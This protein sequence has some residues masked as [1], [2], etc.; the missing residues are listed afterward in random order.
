[1]NFIYYLTCKKQ[2]ETK[3]SKDN[4]FTNISKPNYLMSLMTL[5]NDNETTYTNS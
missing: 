3:S 1:M 5:K 4:C 2:Y